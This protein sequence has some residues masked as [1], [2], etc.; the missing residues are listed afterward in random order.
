MID[1]VVLCY[2]G[3]SDRW[4]A[5]T[6]VTP[7]DF[8]QQL[9]QFLD[10]GYKGATFSDTLT[11]PPFERTLV[12]TFDDAHRSVVQL[13][14]PT[15]HRMGIPGTIYVPTDYAGTDRLMAWD[16]YDKWI[17]TKHEDELA[18]MGWDELRDLAERGWEIGSHTCSHPLLSELGDAE[19]ARELNDSR[20]VCEERMGMP[21]HS[22]AYPYGEFDPRVVRA[23]GEAGYHFA[24]TVP[25]RPVPVLPLA[26]PRVGVYNGENA[27]RVVLR[28]RTRRLN[29][30]T[31]SRAALALKRLR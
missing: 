29:P 9:S 24:S 10:R 18:C 13:A 23:A 26:W 7:A 4:P 31:W 2:H 3:V 6:T 16:G 30:S 21:C 14:A 11:S 1:V 25:R 12:V 22:L 19:L 27:R 8:E 28:A 20:L 17:G 15:M 5:A